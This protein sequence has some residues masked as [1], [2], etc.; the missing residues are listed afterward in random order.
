VNV[1]AYRSGYKALGPCLNPAIAFGSMMLSLDFKWFLQYLIMPFLGALC[2]LV[3]YELVFVKTQDYL[4]EDEEEEEDEGE[5][6][7]D[8]IDVSPP[9]RRKLIHNK[10]IEDEEKVD[11][12][13]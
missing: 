12:S 9:S 5:S 6:L 4:N 11:T 10:E 1:Y 2:S 8:G 7:K 3:F 13:D